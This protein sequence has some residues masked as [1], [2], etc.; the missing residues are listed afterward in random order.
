MLVIENLHV[1]VVKEPKIFTIT[2]RLFERLISEW[3][4]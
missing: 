4:I 2:I 3:F 1:V